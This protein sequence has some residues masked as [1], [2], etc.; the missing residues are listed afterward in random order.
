VCVFQCSAAMSKVNLTESVIVLCR[1]TWSKANK[2]TNKSP[3]FHF[4]ENG[5]TYNCNDFFKN[6]LFIYYMLVHCSCLQTLQKRAS[7]LVT[8]G[9]EPPCGCWVLNSGPSEEQSGALTQ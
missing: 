2:E 3:Q 8:D 5:N 6:Y 7:D 1:P 4:P 9:C